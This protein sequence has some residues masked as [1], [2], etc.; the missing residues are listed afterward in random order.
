M[1]DD[2]Y[3]QQILGTSGKNKIFS[4]HQNSDT[5][6]YHVYYGLEL[7]DV[8]PDN[9]E[10]TR[11]K[12]IIAHMHLVGF[13]LKALQ[14]AFGLDPRTIKKWS[15][16]L[17]SGEADQLEKA[18]LGIG[19]TR[20][21]TEPIKLFVRMRFEQIYPQD[22][23]RYSRKIRAE[24]KEV[25]KEDISS[26]TLRELFGKLKAEYGASS[27]TSNTKGNDSQNSSHLEEPETSLSSALPCRDKE[28]GISQ[29]SGGGGETAGPMEESSENTSVQAT[30]APINRKADTEF[31]GSSWCSHPGLLFFS[32]S[33]SSLQEKLEESTAMP[34]LQWISQVLL[35]A[36]NLEQ[37]K[38]LSMK[39]LELMLGKGLM[40]CPV[41]QRVKLG[42]FASD[43][44]V[45]NTLLRWNF[46]QVQGDEQSEFYFD[47]H[48]KE[49]TGKQ[50]ILKGW[51]SGTRGVE[52]IMNADFVHTRKGQPV[53]F[54]NTDNYEDIRERFKKLQERFRTCFGMAED[55]ELTWIIDR[56]IF[57]HELFHWIIE[58]RKNHLITWEKG[59]QKD[60]WPEGARANGSMIMERARNHSRDLRSYHFEWIEEAWAKH[61][62]WRRFIVR[63]TNPE[64]R[65]IEVSI[66]CDDS[67][68][69]AENI[70]GSIFNRWLQENDF[71]YLNAHFGI[72]QITSYQSVPYSEL[73]DDLEDRTM[74]NSAYLALE[75]ARRAEQTVLG[76]LLV[77]QKKARTE[78]DRRELELC[79]LKKIKELN[80]EQQKKVRALKAGQRS[81]RKHV[82]LRELKIAQSQGEVDDHDQQLQN[83]LKEVSRLQTLIDRG[84]VRLYTDKKYFMDLLKIISRNIFYEMLEPFKK[85]YD[86]YRDDHVWYRHLTQSTTGIIEADEEV[87][88]HLISSTNYPKSVKQVIDDVIALFNQSAQKMPDGS[89]RHIKLI[90]ASTSA[91]GLAI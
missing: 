82:D 73:K 46:E 21:L 71:K 90:W 9:K 75:L 45:I 39:D 50:A 30:L 41:D 81:A 40:G 34:V 2:S 54:E 59:Y 23:Y 64:G 8:V 16:A 6:H 44:D 63:A 15:T 28:L 83:T 49:Y 84:M 91:I 65:E 56:G 20:K 14:E 31:H 70:I 10:D 12:L 4:V 3:L 67:K 66:L 19:S 37:T 35:G 38:L 78:I 52:K 11:F 77:K 57:S 80:V 74:K 62:S 32:E 33:L 76:K 17:K 88:C 85:A 51:C 87:R 26:E 72:N 60:G 86:N 89:G 25:F 5:L 1:K 36:E 24:I 47:P 13:T 22:R 61:T 68:R 53:Y 69:E 27:D 79:E 43:T 48:T 42:Q 55:R 18:L 29:D 58:S 7:F